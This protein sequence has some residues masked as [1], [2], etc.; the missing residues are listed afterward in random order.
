MDII[1]IDHLRAVEYPLV[2]YRCF[3]QQPL[4]GSSTDNPS[5]DDAVEGQP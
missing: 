3:P 5:N 2:G 1:N 4:T